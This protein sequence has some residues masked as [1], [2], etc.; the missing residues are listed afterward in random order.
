MITINIF[1]SK[2]NAIKKAYQ[3]NATTFGQLAE[4]LRNLGLYE[5]D[6]SAVVRQNKTALLSDTPLPTG[7]GAGGIDFD[8]F[9]APNKNKAGT[10]S[11]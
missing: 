6:M 2:T 10:K 4:E 11:K 7:L 9:L 8:L 3:T 1:N 5:T